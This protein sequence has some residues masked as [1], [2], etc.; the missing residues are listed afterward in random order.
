MLLSKNSLQNFF[1]IV[2]TY[3][4]SFNASINPLM[5]QIS[6]IGFIFLLILCLKNDQILETIKIN[7][8][9]NL[10]FFYF[11]ALYIIFLIFQI[12]PLPLDLIKVIAPSNYDLYSSIKIDN[13]FWSISVDPSSSYFSILNCISYFIIFL[14]FPVLFNRKK[15]LMKFLFFMCILG[16]FHAVFA[17]YWMLIGNP[18]NFLI[19][20]IHYLNAS[21]GIFVNR[22]VFATFLFLCSFSGLFYIIIYFQKYQITNFTF[23]EQL[24]SKVFY[25]RIF[26]IFLSIGILTTWSRIVNLSYILILFS[27]LFYSKI[28]FKKIINPLS[29][30]III[31]L[32]FDVLVMAIF[33]GDA[34]LIERVVETSI[35]GETRR[36]ELQS[37][38]WDQFKN[39]WLFGYGSGAF[40]Q[41]FKISYL[42]TED[43]NYNFLVNHVH[44][45]GIEFMGEIGIVG[46]LIVIIPITIYFKKIINGLINNKRL[47]NILILSLLVI[48]L[49]QSLVDFSLHITG[50]SILLMTILA[51]GIINFNKH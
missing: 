14:I 22:S 39:F 38:G 18:S 9:S 6:S 15:Y 44:N 21:T 8:K 48:L 36:L 50:I 32:L 23:S 51:I 28:Y 3:T 34:K 17:T 16:F 45:E 20:K 35:L 13:R 30:I 10:F 2:L 49:L 1:L 24:K 19:E 40:G 43:F 7:Y 11:F 25:I 26:I 42:M 46:I 41:I 47:S 33:F 31:I 29:N 37:F 12:V 27:F 5:T 4:V